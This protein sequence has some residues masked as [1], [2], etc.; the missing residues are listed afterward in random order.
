MEKRAK[1]LPWAKERH[2]QVESHVWIEHEVPT[3]DC[4][5]LSLRL[6]LAAVDAMA[7][8]GPELESGAVRFITG[9]GRHTAGRSTL[10]EA[11]R[12]ALFEL[13]SERQWQVRPSGAA[14]FL[15]I[16]DPKK[17]PASAT[18][19]LGPLFWILVAAVIFGVLAL[20]LWG[21]H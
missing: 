5:D 11:V 3:I 21:P 16:I 12:G 8:L 20:L 17:A 7:E 10:K 9:R 4:H 18:G 19:K 2:W 1:D 6:G 15:L 13:A 14:R